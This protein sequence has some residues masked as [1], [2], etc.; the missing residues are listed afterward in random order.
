MIAFLWK[1]VK[2]LIWYIYLY[3]YILFFDHIQWYSELLLTLYWGIIP[4]GA[5]GTML[6]IDD[7]SAMC[8]TNTLLTVLFFS[9]HIF[10]MSVE[11]LINSFLKKRDT[12]WLGNFYLEIPICSMEP[13][14]RHPWLSVLEF[15]KSFTCILMNSAK[16]FCDI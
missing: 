15:R 4:G 6:G 10:Y 13:Q 14:C 9:R 11:C 7:R 3:T 16:H 5:W 2:L 12:S 1:K 8:K